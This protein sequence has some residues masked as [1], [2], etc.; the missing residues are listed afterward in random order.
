MHSVFKPSPIKQ[1]QLH[2]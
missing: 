1:A 2:L